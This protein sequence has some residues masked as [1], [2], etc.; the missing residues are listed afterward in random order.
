MMLPRINKLRLHTVDEMTHLWEQGSPLHHI[1]ANLQTL[2]VYQCDS[3]INLSCASSY[4]RNITTLD[5]WDCKEMVE[6]ITSSKAQSL[7]GLIILKIRECEMMREVIVSNGDES[8][9]HEIIFRNL[10]CLELY[11]LQN[12]KS[13]CSKNYSLRFPALD[14]VIVS[15]CPKMENFC[16]GA[17]STPKL[18]MVELTRI[19]DMGVG[20][21][22]LMRPLNS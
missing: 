8:T 1:C 2:K 5:V 6:L 10:K 22:T 18:Q 9:D 3:L 13:F 16:G 17:L 7:E 15:N 19:D 11:C 12:L 14:A 20:L 4:F 21:V